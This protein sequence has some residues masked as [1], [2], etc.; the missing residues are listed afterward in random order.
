MRLVLDT[1]VVVSGLRS[2]AGASAALL[3]AALK[4][5]F[6]PVVSVALA[7]EYEATCCAPRH[8]ICSN[9]SEEEVLKVLDALCAVSE[10]VVANYLW[11]PQLRDPNDEMVLEAA[12]NGRAHALVTF[13]RSDLEVPLSHFSIPIWTPQESLRRC[14]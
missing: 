2:P 14:E 8:R 9:L 1:N 7:L 12:V 4:G 13:N 11:R 10:G 6:V 3:R 5:A